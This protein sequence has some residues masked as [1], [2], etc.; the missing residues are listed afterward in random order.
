MLFGDTYKTI[1]CRAQGVYKDRGSRFIAVAYPVNTEAM[2]KQILAEVRSQYHDACH[3]C[4]AYMIGADRQT[5]RSCDDGE[6][7][8]TAGKPILN[9]ILSKDLTNIFVVVVR[10]FGGTLLGVPGLINAY[11]NAAQEALNNA[12]IITK[13]VKDIYEI[14]Y[15]YPVMNDVMKLLKDNETEI[16]S[17]D[18]A[19]NCK[20][21]FSIRKNDS[22]MIFDRLKKLESLKITFVRNE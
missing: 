19:E 7:S 3:H 12:K 4:Y 18:F 17:T 10:Y 9:K 13:T 14:H 6:P 22:V 11:K 20:V 5:Y 16:I 21:I 8:G 15:A 2:A 1:E